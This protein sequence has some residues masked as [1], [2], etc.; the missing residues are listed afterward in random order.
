MKIGFEMSGS[1]RPE[2]G[3]LSKIYLRDTAH[4]THLLLSGSFFSPSFL[5]VLKSQKVNLQ[6][7]D[8]LHLVCSECESSV[9]TSLTV[10]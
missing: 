4:V 10:I 8:R 6:A 3:F 1:H 2:R 5:F 7:L 9:G